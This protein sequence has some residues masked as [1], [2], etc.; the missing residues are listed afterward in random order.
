MSQEAP[1]AH[2]EH[3]G[4]GPW[5]ERRSFMYHD[6]TGEQTTGIV[7][8]RD[9]HVVLDSRTGEA[10]SVPLEFGEAVLRAEELSHRDAAA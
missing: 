9:G 10:L 6:E 1:G 8:F 2:W 4:N 3:F 7:P 5:S